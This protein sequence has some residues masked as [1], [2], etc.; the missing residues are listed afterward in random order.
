MSMPLLV[1]QNIHKML[2]RVT[3]TGQEALAWVAAKA[4]IEAE[5]KAIQNDVPRPP[6]AVQDAVQAALAE[7][8][9]AP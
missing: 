9:P 1:L 7:A 5:I 4:A 6:V 8:P 3:M 2:D